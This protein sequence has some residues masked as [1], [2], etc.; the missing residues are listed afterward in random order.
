MTHTGSGVSSAVIRCAKRCQ[1]GAQGQGLCPINC[2]MACT[3]P[4]GKRA[5]MGSI[6]LRSPSSNSPRT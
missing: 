6:D 5:A 3:F 4:S 2:C 1:T